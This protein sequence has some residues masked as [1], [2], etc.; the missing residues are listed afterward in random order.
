M[1]ILM[2]T[3]TFTPIVGGVE[4]SIRSFSSQLRIQGHQV[5][6][7]AP[8]FEGMMRDEKDVIR[9]PAIQKCN[10]T[11]FSINL[12]IP[13]LLEKL[14]HDFKPDIVHSHHPFLLGDIALRL[15]GQYNI[16][17]IFTYHTMYE[18]YIHYLPFHND[19]IKRFVIE[20]STGYA[21]L[22]DQVIVPTRSVK[23]IL[24]S[25]GVETPTEVIPTGVDTNKFA[26]ADVLKTREEFGIPQEAFVVGHVGRLASEKNLEFLA[27]CVAQFLKEKKDAHFL[28]VGKGPSQEVIKQVFLKED[29]LNR[30]HF[31]GVLRDQQ[32]VDSYHAMNVFAF[33]SLSETQGVVLLEAMASS[34]PV[35]ALDA[36]GV[37]D[38]LRDGLN[39]RLI[40]EQHQETFVSALSWCYHK[41][42]SEM[43][44]IKRAA[45][46]SAQNYSNVHCAGQVINLYNEV[47]SR[48][49]VSRDIH[50]SLWKISMSRIKTEWNMAKNLTNASE[51]AFSERAF[52]V[53]KTRKDKKRHWILKW[54]R[55]CNKH[56]WSARLL[57][58]SHSKEEETKAGLVLIQI[59]G[60]S[61]H[62]L[63]KAIKNNE[64][65]FLKGLLNNQHYNSYPLYTGLPSSTPAVQGELFYGVKQI[66]PAF[67]YFDKSENKV[68][69]MFDGDDAQKIEQRL[70]EQ[71][72]GLLEGGSSYSNIY[73]G[74]A[75]EA[76]FCAVSLGLSRI[77]KD[78]NVFKLIVLALTHFLALIRIILLII[79]EL[80]LGFA[81]FLGGLFQGEN[82]IKEFKFVPTRAVICILLRELITLGVK[83]D[84][85]RGLPIIHLNLL[86]FDEQAHRRGPSTKFAHWALKGIDLA[87]GDIYKNAMSSTRRSYDVWIYS[88]HGQEDT[89]SYTVEYGRRVHE[90]VTEVYSAFK[91]SN[92]KTEPGRLDDDLDKCFQEQATRRGVQFHRASY[93]GSPYLQKL[94]SPQKHAA[95]NK[96][97]VTAIGPTGNIYLPT[98][99]NQEDKCIFSRQLV[100]KA[101]I[102]L[103]LFPEEEGQVRAFNERGEF[104]LPAQA[105]EV[106]G[107]NHPYLSDVTQDL[108]AICHHPD[109]GDFTFSGWR[110]GQTPISFPIENGAHAG[111]GTEETNAFTL[112]PADIVSLSKEKTY[113]KTKDLRELALQH[114]GRMK[115]KKSM[116]SVKS[117]S[118]SPETKKIRIM[119]YN[120]HSCR[121]MDGKTSPER[122]ARVIARHEPDIV[123]L[124]ELDMN[125]SR[126]G[127]INQPHVIAKQ[128]EMM[129]HFHPAICI[130]E[131]RYGNAILSRYPIKTMYAGRLPILP[132]RPD[133]EPRG[134]IWTTIN[135]DDIRVQVINTHLGLRRLERLRQ[136]EALLGP[137]W[138]EHHACEG[139]IIL[140][141]DFNALPGSPVCRCITQK[142][143]D[144]QHVLNNHRPLATWFSHYP[145]GRIDHVFIGGEV[146]VVHAEVSK[147]ELDKVASDHLPL[148]VDL[149]LS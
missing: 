71:E 140:C 56:E 54:N 31:T 120:V 124:Q 45:R 87:I 73:E 48:N 80:V 83:I 110:P 14:M 131:E 15:S 75:K 116:L 123:A 81:D 108:I 85:A 90:A 1:K 23:D 25:R 78:V 146:S 57:N 84:V 138:L 66:V 42:H 104:I 76:H 103:V 95:Q 137:D 3:N 63:Q 147:T 144:S 32:L 82:F 92:K 69:T 111:V 8:T 91:H 46:Q 89:L 97:T 36:Q 117:S 61:R 51:A 47:K 121:G 105:Q 93:L 102:P 9:I 88:D 118:I 27:Q 16:P 20:L 114:L 59:D 19:L 132:G 99:L 68:F 133:L 13:G 28:V 72:T 30:L 29:D 139:P 79:L 55:W 50:N 112:L 143:H 35:V 109:A 40:H 148:I 49:V 101:K 53:K 107:E 38:I 39:G 33:A 115:P 98:K 134:A 58:L 119:T 2:M 136:A 77:W 10:H 7:V 37:R 22:A 44:K 145:V 43:E 67:S 52:N 127:D 149:L 129:Y 106:L 113:L 128:L 96:L 135:V 6:I 26:N 12:P 94:F 130:E 18:Q 65:P 41:S 17:L 122:I 126:T 60:F 21:N 62:Q 86:G 4:E 100:H 24:Q 142:L 141:G 11:D 74:G 5:I 70:K 34:V 64:M 125:R